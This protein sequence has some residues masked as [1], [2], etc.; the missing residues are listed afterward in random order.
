MGA[1]EDS[2]LVCPVEFTAKVSVFSKR[3]K[4]NSCPII[5]CGTA[6][7]PAKVKHQ[8]FLP[9]CVTSS[10]SSSLG[11]SNHLEIKQ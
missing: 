9:F 6:H 8:K 7:T 10:S 11:C 5:F 2:S 4:K 3:F 1:K